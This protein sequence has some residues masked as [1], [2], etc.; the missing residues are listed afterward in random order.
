MGTPL[1]PRPPSAMDRAT[2]LFV[3]KGMPRVRMANSEREVDR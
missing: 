2:E 1:V 3:V